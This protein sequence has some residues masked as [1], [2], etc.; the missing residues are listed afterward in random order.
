M[1]HDVVDTTLA[2]LKKYRIERMILSPVSWKGFKTSLTLNWTTVKYEKSQ[3]HTLP[4]SQGVY[5]FIVKPGIANHPE[6]S[7]L[8]YVGK[9]E[10][11]TFRKRFS[12]YFIE[13][14]KPK[15]RQHIKQMAKLWKNNL[16]YCYAPIS[17]LSLIETVEDGLIE[18][19]VPPLN[20]KYKGTLGKAIKAWL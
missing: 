2:R 4:N 5:T 20:R 9:T 11:Q 19:F 15:G 13:E 6:C 16:W 3:T 14:K 8:L 10:K 18:A 12:Q 17:N 1:A 7:Y